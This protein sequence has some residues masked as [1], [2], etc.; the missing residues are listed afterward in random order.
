MLVDGY[1][2]NGLQIRNSWG[3]NWCRGG[4]TT[5]SWREAFYRSYRLCFWKKPVDERMKEF[6]WRSV[7]VESDCLIERD[8]TYDG[9]NLESKTDVD[10]AGKCANLCYQHP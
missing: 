3:R 1:N 6:N 9:G 8:V 5:M 7:K 2:N 10:S 4:Y